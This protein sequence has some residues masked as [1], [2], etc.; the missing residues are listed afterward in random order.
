VRRSE[1]ISLL[2]S[3]DKVAFV[4][5]AYGG[6]GRSVVEML[7]E[8]GTKV[9]ATDISDFRFNNEDVLHL[10][11]DVTKEKEVKDAIEKC[12]KHFGRLDFV[13]HLAG[14]VGSGRLDAMSLNEWEKVVTTNLTSAFLILKHSYKEIKKPGGVVVLC[15]S[16]NGYNGGSHLSGAAYA[17]SKTALVNLVRYCA[18]EWAPDGI[19]VNIISPGPVNSPMLDRLTEVEMNDLRSSLPLGKLASPEECAGS[20][21]FLCSNHAETMTGTNLNISSG[22]VLDA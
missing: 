11:L 1:T 22:L 16:S 10:P 17:S 4:T 5:G 21:L 15:G 8:S 3:R 7:L 6:I 9:V 12:I 18:K 14:M 13:I 20:I 19:R 2:N